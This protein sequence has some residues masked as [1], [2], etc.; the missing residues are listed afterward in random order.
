MA[1]Q[2]NRVLEITPDDLIF[3]NV[4]LNVAYK[5]VCRRCCFSNFQH[6]RRHIPARPRARHCRGWRLVSLFARSILLI[7]PPLPLH[8]H[9]FE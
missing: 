8:S 3:E 2:H 7:L 6:R 9:R 5:Q 1:T 4:C